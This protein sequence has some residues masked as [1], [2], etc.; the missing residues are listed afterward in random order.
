MASVLNYSGFSLLNFV[1]LF[2]SE[3]D[4]ET[5]CHNVCEEGGL[6]LGVGT[7]ESVIQI[8][9]YPPEVTGLLAFFSSIPVVL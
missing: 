3:R 5:Q 4:H 8:R 7:K 1:A 2:F 6:F 9:L